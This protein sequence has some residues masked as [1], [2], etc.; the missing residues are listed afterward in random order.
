MS[1]YYDSNTPKAPVQEHDVIMRGRRLLD[2]TGVKQVES[3]DNEE[4]LLETVMGFLAIKGQNLQ[5]KNLDV[6]KGIV[7]IKGK[8]FDLV[9]LD[10]Q[11][12]EKAKG[13]FSKLF[14]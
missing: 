6:D 9:Y 8:I 10:D 13:F 11:H 7:S 12:G 4:F 5:M 3:F 2:I 1:Q 14:R